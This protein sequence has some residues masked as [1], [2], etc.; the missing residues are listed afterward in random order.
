MTMVAAGVLGGVKCPL[1]RRG[2]SHVIV[3]RGDIGSHG[4]WLLS[5]FAVPP[6]TTATTPAAPAAALTTLTGGTIARL[7]RRFVVCDRRARTRGAFGG[8]GSGCSGG[9]LVAPFLFA[10]T[11]PLA[12]AF[13]IRFTLGFALRVTLTFAVLVGFLFATGLARRLRVTGMLARRVAVTMAGALLVAAAF[14]VTVAV[15]IFLAVAV[16]PMGTAA[17]LA[18]P[19]VAVVAVAMTV[20]SAVPVTMSFAPRLAGRR[21]LLCPLGRLAGEQISQALPEAQARGR[22]H[23]IGGR[24]G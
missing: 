15:A 11:L 19:I 10:L 5:A 8:A 24:R 18:A 22:N 4:G 14:F 16:P 9:L 13:A 7:A 21:G 2:L 1:F 17:G 3:A 20:A 12:I 6:A 23:D